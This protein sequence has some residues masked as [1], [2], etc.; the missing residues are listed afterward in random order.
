MLEIARCE[1]NFNPYALNVNKNKST[2]HSYFQINSLWKDHFIKRGLDI[3]NP[4]DNIKAAI[5]L[6]E[7][8]GDSPWKWSRNCWSPRHLAY[9]QVKDV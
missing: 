2:D 9:T 8:Y 7:E 5:I 6:F 4:T 3:E 1:S